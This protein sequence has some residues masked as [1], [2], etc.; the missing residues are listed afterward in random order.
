MT[1]TRE[2]RAARVSAP[3]PARVNV[4]ATCEV[5]RAPIDGRLLVRVL[6]GVEFD[7]LRFAAMKMYTPQ[8]TALLFR[9]G[10]L[11]CVGCRSIGAA[12]VACLRVYHRLV[13]LGYASEA[14]FANFR[15][16]NIVCHVSCGFSVDLKALA[17]AHSVSAS[18]DPDVFPGLRFRVGRHVAA[19][20]RTRAEPNFLVFLSGECVV[21]GSRDYIALQSAW[22]WFFHN[23]LP[24]FRLVSGGNAA[25][26]NA[27]AALLGQSPAQHLIA[28]RSGGTLALVPPLQPRSQDIV[29]HS[30]SSAAYR[31]RT[32]AADA[33]AALAPRDDD[34][35]ARRLAALR[36]DGERGDAKRRRFEL[37]VLTATE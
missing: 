14:R 15:V 34:A 13:R 19:S 30:M 20:R 28:F 8:S 17:A 32:A 24:N 25:P 9:G 11:V 27:V 22:A 7:P 23:I 1:E 18:Y 36:G 16:E 6:P 33:D 3:K 12:R 10:K 21:T 29:P 31:K 2:A 37:P 4:V 26:G 5:T 35:D